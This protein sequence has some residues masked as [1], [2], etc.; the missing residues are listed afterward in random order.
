MQIARLWTL[1]P[2]LQ[3]NGKILA[4]DASYLPRL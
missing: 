3:V 4:G 2:A 1:L